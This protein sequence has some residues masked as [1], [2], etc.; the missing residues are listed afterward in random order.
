MSRTR[1]ERNG[2]LATAIGMVLFA[3]SGC[4]AL[5]NLWGLRTAVATEGTVV[6]N[7]EHP[8]KFNGEDRIGYYPVV[9]YL[10]RQGAARRAEPSFHREK[11]IPIGTRLPVYYSPDDPGRA[12]VGGSFLWDWPIGMAGIGGFSLGFGCLLIVI[13]RWLARHGV[14]MRT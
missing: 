3:A 13:S 10:D 8:F 9:E 6:S 1:G 5:G 12:R 2:W 14:P 7:R 11:P 4:L